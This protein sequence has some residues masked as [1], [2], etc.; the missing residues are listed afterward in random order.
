M[1]HLS[2]VSL[3]G[4]AEKRRKLLDQDHDIYIVNHHGVKTIMSELCERTD[5]DVVIIDELAIYRNKSTELWKSAR[6]V[7]LN[8]KFV[9]GLTGSPTPREPADAWAQIMLITPNRTTKYYKQ[10]RELTMNQVSQFRWLPKRNANDIVYEQM[11]P[12]VRYNRSD[13][14]DL[15]PTTYTTLEA[16]LEK[17]QKVAYVQLR[18]NCFMQL[19]EGKATAANEGVLVSKLLQISCGF[20]Y[21]EDHKVGNIPNT[22]RME[23]LCDTIDQ[24]K[25]KVIVFTPFVESVD[26][27]HAD[28]LG[29]GYDVVKVYGD[30]PKAQRDEI[31][32]LFQHSS[33]HRVIVA[34]PQCM[35]H[36]LTL[37]AADTIVWF[38]P[39]MSL[40]IYEQA[41]ARI[42]RPGQKHNTL[43]VH[44]ESTPMERKIYTRLRNRA[45]VQGALLELFAES[46]PQVRRL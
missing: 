39:P 37:T 24:T 6:A 35:A 13:C 32:R 12:A 43:I 8:R 23:V 41:N 30:T 45:A 25:N 46:N 27:I 19:T 17:E 36:G 29:K 15:P 16:E 42:T 33:S 4:S 40:E 21:T 10:F 38:C 28:L 26:R 7:T 34:H 20:L 11:Q 31:F 18:D 3:H 1:R 5:I 22:K 2:A 44:L 14:V 9:W